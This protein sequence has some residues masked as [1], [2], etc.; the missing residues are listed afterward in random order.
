M[1]GVCIKIID[2]E[3]PMPLTYLNDWL[4]IK[5]SFCILIVQLKINKLM[6]NKH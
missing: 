5:L 6:I 1:S 4:T 3:Y 2:L